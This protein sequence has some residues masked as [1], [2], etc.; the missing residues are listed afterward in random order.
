MDA[1]PPCRRIRRLKGA[2]AVGGLRSPAVSSAHGSLSTAAPHLLFACSRAQSISSTWQ[3]AWPGMGLNL[4]NTFR[5]PQAA[6]PALLQGLRHGRSPWANRFQSMPR[7]TQFARFARGCGDLWQI[8]QRTQPLSQAGLVGPGMFHVQ[9]A[10]AGSFPRQIRWSR[11]VR[12]R[13]S[14]SVGLPVRLQRPSVGRSAEVI[15]TSLPASPDVRLR[16]SPTGAK[17]LR[18]RD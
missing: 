13:L 9:A 7:L 2:V 8:L 1:D 15:P 6:S 14:W 18:H 16:H 5:E 4:P 3:H 17:M 10:R 11:G 12:A